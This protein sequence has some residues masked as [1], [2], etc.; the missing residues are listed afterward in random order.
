[1]RTKVYC[2]LLRLYPW[3]YRAMFAAG[4]LH[5]FENEAEERPGQRRFVRFF[6]AELL[7]LTIGA[8]TEWIAK[9]TTD[10]SV[11]GRCLPDVRMMRPPG[12]PREIWFAGVCSRDTSR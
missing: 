10:N 6:L 12:I 11:R 1:M 5:A 9:W 3:D 4:M 7:G 2:V 8:G